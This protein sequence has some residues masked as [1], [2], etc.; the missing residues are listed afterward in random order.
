MENISLWFYRVAVRNSHDRQYALCI[1]VCRRLT[2]VSSTEKTLTRNLCQLALDE[3]GGCL[4][5][6]KGDRLPSGTF[7]LLLNLEACNLACVC[8]IE[9]T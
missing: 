4:P 2:S 3:N 9:I 1:R 7:F 5:L 8:K 6:S